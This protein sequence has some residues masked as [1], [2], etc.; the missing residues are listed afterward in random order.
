MRTEQPPYSILNRGIERDVLPVC[1][2]YGMGVMVWSPLAM[3]ML[4]GCY[5]RGQEVESRRT[6]LFARQMT[7]ARRLDAVEQLIPLAEVA[8]SDELL[9]KIDEIV[10]PGTD[11]GRLEA[12][13]E[14]PAIAQAPLRRRPAAERSARTERKDSVDEHHG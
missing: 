2:R 5:R 6:A 11:I 10:A 13:Y 4:T 9:D 7:D 12:A 1:Q 8:L 14:P 3:G